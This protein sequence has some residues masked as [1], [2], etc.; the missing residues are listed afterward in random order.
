LWRRVIDVDKLPEQTVVVRFDFR[1][2]P[3]RPFWVLLQRPEP[4]VCVKN[5]GLGTD[6]VVTTETEWLG[7]WQMGPASARGAMRAGLIVFQGPQRLVHSFAR[8]GGISPFGKG[9]GRELAAFGAA[10][11]EN[12]PTMAPQ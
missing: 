6:L 5:P 10:E 9:R 2:E 1:D 8:W 7:K 3:K 4:E 11:P 12:V